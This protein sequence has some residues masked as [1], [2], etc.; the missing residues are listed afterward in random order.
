MEPFNFVLE[1]MKGGWV[2]LFLQTGPWWVYSDTSPPCATLGSQPRAT[3]ALC[4]QNPEIFPLAACFVLPQS[5]SH[6]GYWC[7]VLPHQSSFLPFLKSRAAGH[8]EENKNMCWWKS[9]WIT[10]FKILYFPLWSQKEDFT[11]LPDPAHL[12]FLTN[13]GGSACFSFHQQPI[14]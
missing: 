2:T 6:L 7:Q 1:G 9:Q 11:S 8:P 3:I 5:I 13:L 12:C 4:W 10:L 14:N